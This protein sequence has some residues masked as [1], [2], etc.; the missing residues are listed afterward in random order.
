MVVMAVVVVV[1][2]VVV[3]VVVVVAVV[4]VVVVV[5]AAQVF[6]VYPGAQ[7]QPQLLPA[8][9][10]LEEP[11]LRHLGH[12]CVAGLH[13]ASLLA[14]PASFTV[15]SGQALCLAHS[16]LA[17]SLALNVPL[18]QASHFAAFPLL[19]GTNF[20]PAAHFVTGLHTASLP[21]VPFTAGAS[22]AFCRIS[23]FG[24]DEFLARSAL[25]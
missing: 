24:G 17:S 13:T 8:T 23:I 5:V 15:V 19:A 22:F 6:P 21:A 12:V 3:M 14:V 7:S 18:A 9:E 4:M 1:V 25:C 10:P 16:V 20:L 11:P 2:V